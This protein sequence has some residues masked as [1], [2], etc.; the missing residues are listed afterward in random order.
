[1]SV[2]LLPDKVLNC[3]NAGAVAV[4]MCQTQSGGPMVMSAKDA[5]RGRLVRIPA[6]M[7]DCDDGQVA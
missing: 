4:L 5:K 7:V 6:F 1:M 2:I 3:Q